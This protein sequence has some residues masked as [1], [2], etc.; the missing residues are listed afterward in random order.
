MQWYGPIRGD[1]L[2]EEYLS[3]SLKDSY[4]EISAV[5]VWCARISPRSSNIGTEPAF[6]EWI[7][8]ALKRP[9]GRLEDQVR[10]L[11]T[12]SLTLGGSSLSPNKLD[13]LRD[14]IRTYDDRRV[15]K[16]MLSELDYSTA[17][18]VGETEDLQIRLRDHLSGRSD[19]AQ[20]CKQFGYVWQDLGLRYLQLP[21]DVPASHRRT[22][23]RVLAVLLLAPAT[24]R[25]G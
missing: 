10:H 8:K 13:L 2:E 18:Y 5:Y 20:R 15:F 14:L 22:L 17:L 6:L 11:G 4:S 24:S 3:G 9:R 23:E 19:F 16:A 1:D 25:A 21:N 12:V 7:Q